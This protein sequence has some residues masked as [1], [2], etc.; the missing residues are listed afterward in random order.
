[1]DTSGKRRAGAPRDGHYR[2]MTHIDAIQ[3]LC[4]ELGGRRLDVFGSATSDAFDPNRSDVD[5]L[6]DYA[7]ETDLGLWWTRHFEFQ[8]RLEALLGRPVD[9]VMAGG[10][11]ATR[12]SSGPS[13]RVAS[14][15]M[16]AETRKLLEDLRY[17]SARIMDVTD[18]Q[19]SRHTWPA[20]ISRISSSDG[21]RSS[22]RRCV[23]R[24]SSICRLPGD[25]RRI[26][27]SSRF[28][29]C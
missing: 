4:R 25:S 16:P 1:M 9:L 21:S 23:D 14:S 8:E 13:G 27:R 5:L 22:A 26:S 7:P 10:G 17:S 6:V 18:G 28:A 11:C 3:D 20:S 15:C 2:H 19:T 24:Q 12:T 29:T